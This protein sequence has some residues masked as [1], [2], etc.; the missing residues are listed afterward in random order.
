MWRTF[1]AETKRVPYHSPLILTFSSFQAKI[2]SPHQRKRHLQILFL[3]QESFLF[4]HFLS[5][6]LFEATGDAT[7]LGYWLWPTGLPCFITTPS[8]HL[9]Y[10]QYIFCVCQ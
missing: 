5:L 6:M 8:G 9:L 2:C 7:T 3:L 10:L 1:K 4:P